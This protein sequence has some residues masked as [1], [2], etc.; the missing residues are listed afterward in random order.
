VP[1]VGL[2]A[3][4][5]TPVP[6]AEQVALVHDY[7]TQ[8][9]GAERTVLAM[10][11]AFPG[12][13]LYTSLYEPEATFPE[14]AAMDVR[15]LAL[16]AVPLLR[17]RHRLAFPFLAPSFAALTI[18]APVTVVSS[19]GWAH[20]VRVTGRK[21]VYCHAPA[22]WLYQ[23]DRYL[24][25][26]RG[27]ARAT[28]AILDGTLRSW[29]RRAALSADRYLTN[30]T[31]NRERI[32]ECYGIDAEVVPPPST[33]DVHA[34]ARAVGVLE[35]GFI[36]CVSRLL[37][38]KNVEAILA[39]AAGGGHQWVVAGG[40]PELQ[41]LRAEAPTNVHLLGRVDDAQLRWLYSACTGLVAPSYEDFGLTPVEAALFGKPV[42]A[43]RGGGYLDT[44]VEG[45]TGVFFD[46]A[47]PASIAAAAGELLARPWDADAI[48][49]WGGRFGIATFVG[50]L[51]DVVREELAA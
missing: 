29:D 8:R 9:G 14:L 11:A 45:K 19:S 32:R 25:E 49:R 15:C 38:Y 33:L 40:G 39:A 37:P 28:L 24:G 21:V 20:G 50:R 36:L 17:R 16:N 23:R 7:L 18:D 22:R 47:Q 2:A 4:A 46:Q 5:P 3:D 6:A 41:R 27:A 35:P 30:S 48:R 42:A 1:N 13:P 26:R 44:I 43:L 12:A 34:P 31:V 51:R 10:A